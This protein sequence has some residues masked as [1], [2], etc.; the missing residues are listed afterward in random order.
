MK[1]VKIKRTKVV[2]GLYRFSNGIKSVRISKSAAFWNVRTSDINEKFVWYADA[3]K[4][5]KELLNY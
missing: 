1:A 4:R 2:D 5:V 3:E